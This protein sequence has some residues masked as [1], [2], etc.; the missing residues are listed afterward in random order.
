MV[1][2]NKCYVC[3][4]KKIKIERIYDFHNMTNQR[5]EFQLKEVLTFNADP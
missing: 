2:N 1:E 5:F 4:F 3:N